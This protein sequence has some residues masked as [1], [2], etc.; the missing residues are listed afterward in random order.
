M[1]YFPVNVYLNHSIISLFSNREEVCNLNT[2]KKWIY[3]AVAA[4]L[5]LSLCLLSVFAIREHQRVYSLRE[6]LILQTVID[7]HT[8]SDSC[9]QA[10]T[11]ADPT[12]HLNGSMLDAV[13]RLNDRLDGLAHHGVAYDSTTLWGSD[14]FIHGLTVHPGL[15]LLTKNLPLISIQCSER[16]ITVSQLNS[17][18]K[19]LEIAANSALEQLIDLNASDLSSPTP[20][21]WDIH[22]RSAA[23]D[24]G[25]SQAIRNF[26]DTPILRMTP[27]DF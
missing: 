19:E 11:A 4:F 6:N 26:L 15:E 5:L 20:G 23:F 7:L 1:T 14:T 22:V 25:Y 17:W 16:T 13:L 10:A 3:R 2:I 12:T 24:D 18:L 8:I 27:Q 9:H 21:D